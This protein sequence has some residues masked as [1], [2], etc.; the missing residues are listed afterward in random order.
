M[1]PIPKLPNQG[2]P[3]IDMAIIE[4]TGDYNSITGLYEE[5]ETIETSFKGALLPLSQTDLKYSDGTYTRE[6]KKIYCERTLKENDIIKISSTNDRYIINRED[7]Y[8]GLPQ[9]NFR[10]YFA[11]RRKETSR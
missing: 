8:Q 7:D 9:T 4:T 6:Y 5:T 1:F 3:F 10:I 2:I 11:K